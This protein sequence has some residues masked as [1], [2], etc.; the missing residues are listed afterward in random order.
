MRLSIPIALA[1]LFS[2]SVCSEQTEGNKVSVYQLINTEE[3]QQASYPMQISTGGRTGKKVFVTCSACHG[4]DASKSAL[5]QSRIIRGWEPSKITKAL[6]GYRSGTYGGAMKHIMRGQA[7]AL[8][9]EEIER[10][11]GY[12]SQ[13]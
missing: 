10:V 4:S 1:L 7:S 2:I 12:I 3:V 11:A 8:T 13:L 6:N 9:E 5:G